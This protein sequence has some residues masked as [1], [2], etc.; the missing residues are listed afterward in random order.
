MNHIIRKHIR[1]LLSEEFSGNMP[2]M[3][4]THGLSAFLDQE[5]IFG[6]ESDIVSI[7]EG[8]PTPEVRFALESELK[9][10]NID[11]KVEELTV[12]EMLEYYLQLNHLEVYREKLLSFVS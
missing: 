6:M 3:L 9:F 11:K 12:E 5:G 1:K 4:D 10:K 8:N 2:T 7:L